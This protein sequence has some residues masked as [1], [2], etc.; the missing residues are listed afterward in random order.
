[1]DINHGHFWVV[2]V[3]CGHPNLLTLL[4]HGRHVMEEVNRGEKKVSNEYEETLL[5]QRS[6]I[7]TPK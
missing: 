4:G 6:R 3:S 2:S 5:T 7:N 1:M